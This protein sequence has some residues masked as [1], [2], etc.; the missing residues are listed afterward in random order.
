M[1]MTPDVWVRKSQ[2]GDQLLHMSD[3][4]VNPDDRETGSSVQQPSDGQNDVTSQPL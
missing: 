3:G 1:T 4:N 2:Q